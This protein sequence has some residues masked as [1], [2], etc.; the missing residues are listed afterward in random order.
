M[1]LRVADLLARSFKVM[2]N[3]SLQELSRTVSHALRHE[4]WLYELEL[5]AQGWVPVEDLL[6]ALRLQRPEWSDLALSDVEDMIKRSDKQRH[7]L[8][9]HRIRARYGHSVTGKLAMTLACPPPVLYHGT[10]PGAVTLI[11]K[12]GLLPMKR[13][14]VHLSGDQETALAVGQRKATHPVIL[15][16]A[17]NDAYNH[18]IH[19]YVGNVH[20]WLADPIPPQFIRER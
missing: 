6:Q 19:F 11:L 8:R 1:Q 14:Y 13:Q 12:E 15:C 4:P 9:A 10:S 16:V 2:N 5:D 7:E 3:Q 18:G 20:V 17:A